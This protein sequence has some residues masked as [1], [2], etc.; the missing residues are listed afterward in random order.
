MALLPLWILVDFFVSYQLA[1][2]GLSRS[3]GRCI[4][5]QHEHRIS[6]RTHTYMHDWDSNRQAQSASKWDVSSHIHLQ[7]RG[8]SDRSDQSQFLKMA[9]STVY[10]RPRITNYYRSVLRLSTDQFFH[11][12]QQ[13]YVPSVC[14]Q[15]L[16][17]S[18]GSLGCNE[19]LHF[20]HCPVDYRTYHHHRVVTSI[21][22]T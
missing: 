18:S 20:G 13:E 2:R 17:Y 8:R 22:K 16:Y 19:F 4:H 21:R 12:L 7:P 9:T 14:L 10:K 5:T 11:G 6:A 3:E 1:E 15:I